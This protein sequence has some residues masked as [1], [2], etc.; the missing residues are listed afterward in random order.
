MDSRLR[1]HLFNHTAI[2]KTTDN[3]SVVSSD[4]YVTST[5]CLTKHVTWVFFYILKHL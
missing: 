4:G 2:A 3:K 1:V 5:M